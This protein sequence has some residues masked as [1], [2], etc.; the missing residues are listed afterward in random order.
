MAKKYESEIDPDEFIRS[1]REEPSSL[2]SLNRKPK[3][4]PQSDATGSSEQKTA[5]VLSVKSGSEQPSSDEERERLFRERFITRTT[6][7]RPQVKFLMVEIDPVIIGKI[8][9]LIAFENGS[10]SLKSYINNVLAAHFEEYA[11]VINPKL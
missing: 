4:S 2:S 11:D 3:E 7:L 6:Y 8:K 5:T 1:F 9:R 10:C